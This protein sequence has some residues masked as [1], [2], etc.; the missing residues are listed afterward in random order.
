MEAREVTAWK[1]DTQM[2]GV[3]RKP[4]VESGQSGY[5]CSVVS[6]LVE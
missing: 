3:S 6:A 1:Y 2:M 4:Q 5:L